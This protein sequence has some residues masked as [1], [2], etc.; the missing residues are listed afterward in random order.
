MGLRLKVQGAEG[1]QRPQCSARTRRWSRWR[2]VLTAALG[3]PLS[4]TVLGDVAFAQTS[5][6][7]APPAAPVGAAAAS[8][9]A[10]PPSVSLDVKGVDISVKTS[11]SSAPD[12]GDTPH[13]CERSTD[14]DKWLSNDGALTRTVVVAYSSVTLPWSHAC[15]GDPSS[16]EPS[17]PVVCLPQGNT[18]HA[19]QIPP[20]TS[21]RVIVVGAA[22]TPD[23]T[24]I[25]GH[26]AHPGWTANVDVT[27]GPPGD[28]LS[29]LTPY[30]RPSGSLHPFS[31]NWPPACAISA[32]TI[33][34]RTT[35]YTVTVQLANEKGQ[36]YGAAKR[37]F[38]IFI[39]NTSPMACTP[40]YPAEDPTRK[41]RSLTED[42]GSDTALAHTVIVAYG[43][44]HL[45]VTV[46]TENTH[47]PCVGQRSCHGR[48]L[49]SDKNCDESDLCSGNLDEASPN[50]PVICTGH[51]ADRRPFQ[52]E[53]N[54]SARVIVI[55][56]A[57]SDWTSHVTA[58]GDP[59]LAPQQILGADGKPGPLAGFSAL[60][61]SSPAQ[62]PD[63]SAHDTCLSDV[64]TI[65]PRAGGFHIAV[66]LVDEKGTS[67][68][69]SERPI[70]VI[71]DQKYIGAI[72][73]GIG[74][75]IPYDGR[76]DTFGTSVYGVHQ[77]ANG[78]SVINRDSWSPLDLD[79]I[80]GYTAFFAPAHRSVLELG[81][82][83]FF[84][85]SGLLSVS[86]STGNVT[87]I[88]SAYGGF[89]YSLGGM[90]FMALIGVHR[91]NAIAA[92]YH[93]GQT[94]ASSASVNATSYEPSF[95]VM[96]GYTAD[97]FKIPGGP[98]K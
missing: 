50:H 11:K 45:P 22:E 61:A 92:P 75:T 88:T 35:G 77:A 14:L 16:A 47:D 57:G 52:L 66:A 19:G 36:A 10:P 53:P 29:K 86:P 91:E 80:A 64:W 69:P 98:S 8:S 30:P 58:S 2:V 72:R 89:E 49:S 9:A 55:R 7:A 94:V 23:A 59:Q 32:W 15:S 20:H 48:S 82:P 44:T 6:V 67:Y 85:G 4:A 25:A 24:N 26:L 5:P 76:S 18:D 87:A 1:A 63:R 65:A 37:D 74:A 51:W 97:V 27:N 12:P 31:T 43:P 39:G 62:A 79:L 46:L 13:A 3:G 40:P 81:G 28:T 73:V 33:G 38:N 41:V 42:I 17:R 93:D 78:A 95:G 60:G 34:A 56:G 70:E 90:Q 68:G 71:V 21:L 83:G 84:F 54:T 96:F